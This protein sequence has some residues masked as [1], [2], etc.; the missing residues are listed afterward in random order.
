[1]LASNSALGVELALRHHFDLIITDIKM[2]GMDGVELVKRI[3]TGNPWI[4]ILIIT[5]FESQA[6]VSIT[7]TY[8]SV[9][10]LKKPFKQADL[11]NII[12][13]VFEGKFPT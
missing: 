13:D 11:K 10:L 9:G 2:P 4:P 6:A 12:R 7:N 5:G 1:M 3:K 8:E